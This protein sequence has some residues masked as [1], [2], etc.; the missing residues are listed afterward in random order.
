[1]PSTFEKGIIQWKSVYNIKILPGKSKSHRTKINKDIHIWQLVTLKNGKNMLNEMHYCVGTCNI[2]RM[3]GSYTR[4][5]T[6]L[7]NSVCLL[8]CCSHLHSCCFLVLVL[9]CSDGCLLCMLCFL[10]ELFPLIHIFS[11]HWYLCIGC[12]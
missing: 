4:H 11:P 9:C 10:H 6:G 3:S 5:S 1:M 8:C 2:G 7:K 12:K